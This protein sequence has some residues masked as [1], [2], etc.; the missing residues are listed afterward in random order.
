[1]LGVS[2]ILDGRE[3][4]EAYI[5]VH[6]AAE[7]DGDDGLVGLRNGLVKVEGSSLIL[8]II[9]DAGGLQ[10]ALCLALLGADLCAVDLE[11]VSIE[12]DFLG[13]L[14]DLDIDVDFAL[15]RP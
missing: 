9:C 13:L 12:G 3:K 11:L 4:V 5:I 1:M 10:G 14:L 15:V 7:A 6:D 8:L 2:L